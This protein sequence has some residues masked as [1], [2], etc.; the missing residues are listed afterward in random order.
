MPSPTPIMLVFRTPDGGAI[1][2]EV[3][4]DG[5]VVGRAADCGVRLTDE[6][7]SR[8]HCRIFRHE[9]QAFVEDLGSRNGTHVN[10]TPLTAR[11][12]LRPG[13]VVVVGATEIELLAPAGLR[14]HAD[15]AR[16]PE[17][18]AV[19]DVTSLSS[20]VRRPELFADVRA[21]N[22]ALALLT[23]A[24]AEL[25]STRPLPEVLEAVLD[26]ALEGLAADRAAVALLP[27]DTEAASDDLPRLDIAAARGRQGVADLR[28]SR[29]VARMV[30]QERRAVAVTDVGDMRGGALSDS[31]RL[32]GVRSLACAP[33]WDGNRVVGLFW[34]DRRASGGGYGDVDVKIL[35][36]LAN[37]VAIKIENAKLEERALEGERLRE[38]LAVARRIQQRLLP[39][40]GPSELGLD[41][42]GACL[43]C[44]EVGGDLF[45]WLPFADDRIG[46]L[47]VDACGKGVGAALLAASVQAALRGGRRMAAAP[48]ERLT[49]LNDFLHDHAPVESYVTAALVEVDARSGDVRHAVAGH[50]PPLLVPARGPARLLREGGLP[51]GMFA[52]SVYPGASE[53]LEPGGK[54]VLYSDGI[55]EAGRS[56]RRGEPFGLERLAA[57]VR[58]SPASAEACCAAVLAALED[59]SGGAP[60]R[61]DA[62]LLV[63]LRG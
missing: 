60:L 11:Q 40:A 38:E 34:I 8:R 41:V 46:L 42:F 49:W 45:D 3:L 53:R 28:V 50:P 51:L 13:D 59:F 63:C 43:P 33:L 6:S 14:L 25:M 39:S 30:V 4:A 1:R 37:V 48:D 26:L 27:S 20:G 58:E 54:L 55:T 36:M 10:G 2:R 17:T 56:G 12:R 7:L 62:T 22:R 52:G 19:F 47:V 61:D 32:Q 9:G 57:I 29:T 35:S 16:A 15:E 24:G 18:T 23:R 31:V 5:L 44:L 21:E